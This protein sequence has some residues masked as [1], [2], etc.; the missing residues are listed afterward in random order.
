IFGL[1][2]FQFLGSFFV[3]LFKFAFLLGGFSFGFCLFVKEF[4]KLCLHF[5]ILIVHFVK[6]AFRNHNLLR[7][8]LFLGFGVFRLRR[9][10]SSFATGFLIG[11]ESS[12][13]IQHSYLPPCLTLVIAVGS[14]QAQI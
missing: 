12:E 1:R 2:I 4:V 10:F 11:I 14:A 5:F 9:R 3:Q 7:L 8:L 13:Q 6:P